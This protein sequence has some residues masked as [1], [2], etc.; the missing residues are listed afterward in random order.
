MTMP[1]DVIANGVGVFLMTRYRHCIHMTLNVLY[2]PYTK[3]LDS[4]T[5]TI[6]SSHFFL[7][8]NGIEVSSKLAP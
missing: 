2:N 4:K 8:R 1:S 6:K 7:E 3:F 5:K